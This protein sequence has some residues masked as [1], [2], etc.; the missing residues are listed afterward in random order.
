MLFHGFYLVNLGILLPYSAYQEVRCFVPGGAGIRTR[1][2]V[3]PYQEVR[4][5]VPGGAVGVPGG[6]EILGF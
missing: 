6:A 1:R 4:K 2:C 5:I 3:F